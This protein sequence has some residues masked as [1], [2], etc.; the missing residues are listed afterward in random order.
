MPILEAHG[1]QLEFGW[2]GERTPGRPTLV[3]MHH[4]LGSVEQWRDF[5]LK[6]S[7]ATGCPAFAYS[8]VGYAG[9]DSAQWPWPVDI[10]KTDG[11]ERLPKVLAAAGIDDLILV[12]HSDGA[13]I[14]LVYGADVRTG[15][16]GIIVEAPHL[17]AQ[18]DNIEEINRTRENYA[19]GDLRERLKKFHGENVDSA[20]YGWAET[21]I[22]PA[23]QAFSIE[24]LIP[25][26]E[27]PV[28]AIRGVEDAYC[29]SKQIDQLSALAQCSLQVAAPDCGHD[30]H[31]EMEAEMLDLMTGFIRP[32]LD[33]A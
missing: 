11:R 12:G 17:F 4:G 3:F 2:Y 9:S 13:S 26:I 18:T 8:R 14:S 16:R 19:S 28:L 23:F 20:F 25:R 10:F 6:L 15:L 33:P 5:P 1:N 31:Q 27:V 32:L 24:D 7:E 22:Q 21:W 29:T 30:P